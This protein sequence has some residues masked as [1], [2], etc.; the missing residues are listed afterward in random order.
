ML[1]LINIFSIRVSTYSLFCLLGIIINLLYSI[2]FAKY[3]R[4]KKQYILYAF[5]YEIIGA[6]I[7]AKVYYILSHLNYYLNI[8]NEFHYE[9][10][11][12]SMIS[13]VSFTGFLI[14]RNNRCFCILKKCKNKNRQAFSNIASSAN[15][16]L[17]YS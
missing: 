2:Y 11:L 17:W 10:I 8:F 1:P 14:R 13:G 12:T 15:F 3:Y 16:I 7:G 5:I 9:E 6:L 4:I